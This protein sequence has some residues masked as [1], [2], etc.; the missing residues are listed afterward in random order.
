MILYEGYIL[1]T[2]WDIKSRIENLDHLFMHEDFHKRYLYS[3]TLKDRKYE[4]TLKESSDGVIFSKDNIELS[5]ND[6]QDAR[7]SLFQQGYIECGT[8]E[9]REYYY[10]IDSVDIHVYEWPH[11]PK[12]LKVSG[13]NQDIIFKVVEKMGY[14]KDD[15]YPYSDI[16]EI[17]ERYSYTEDR[18]FTLMFP[19]EK[20][21]EDSNLIPRCGI[22]KDFD[23]K[24]IPNKVRKMNYESSKKN[25]KRKKL[26]YRYSRQVNK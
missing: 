3:K 1:G 9:Y 14:T 18:T 15:L 16:R 26:E 12:F 22:I 5:T 19:K 6:L 10:I 11:I 21:K 2:E 13:T 8:Q 20:K 7:N 24:W 23:T 25:H 17:Y 4:F